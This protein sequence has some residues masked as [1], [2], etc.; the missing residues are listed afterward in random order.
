VDN[1]WTGKT[2]SHKDQAVRVSDFVICRKVYLAGGS[3][4]VSLEA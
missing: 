3:S 1:K 2:S 4:Y